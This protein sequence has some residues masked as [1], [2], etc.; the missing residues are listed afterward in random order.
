MAPGQPKS[1]QTW[2]T[3]FFASASLPAMNM[4][5][6]PPGNFGETM[7]AFPTVL[8]H[9]T[10]R[11]FGSMRCTSSPAEVLQPS[12][13]LGGAPL[14]KSSALVVSITTLPAKFSGF[15]SSIACCVPSHN[16][17]S[18][19]SSPNLAVSS[20]VPAEALAPFF[21]TQAFTLSWPGSRV[22]SFTSCPRATNPAP[23]VCPT[24]PDPNTPTFTL[25]TSLASRTPRPT[26]RAPAR[27]SGSRPRAPALRTA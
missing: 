24:I 14:L 6:G 16:V 22:P 12:A 7:C 19:R 8:K 17:E 15:A 10:T 23:R 1:V 21:W 11:A 27:G 9:F 20:N 25:P 2:A 5:G 26:R 4:S 3:F 18:T 13:S